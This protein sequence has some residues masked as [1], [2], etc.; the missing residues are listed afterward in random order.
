[1][2]ISNRSSG[3]GQGQGD[4]LIISDSSASIDLTDSANVLRDIYICQLDVCLRLCVSS[5][6]DASV[7]NNGFR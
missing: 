3:D 2:R 7:S 1:M 6:S 5:F 4:K